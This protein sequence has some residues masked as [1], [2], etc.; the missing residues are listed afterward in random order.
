VAGQ[1]ILA[2][3]GVEV[4]YDYGMD[5]LLRQG[6]GIK[7]ENKQIEFIDGLAPPAPSRGRA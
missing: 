6:S 4:Q 5:T 7:V 1:L 2:L 3:R